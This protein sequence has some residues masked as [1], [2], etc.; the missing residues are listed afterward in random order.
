MA[1]P[2]TWQGQS[3]W[4]AAR[5][6]VFEDPGSSPGATPASPTRPPASETP[7]GALAPTAGSG[8]VRPGAPAAPLPDLEGLESRAVESDDSA[9]PRQASNTV[10]RRSQWDWLDEQGRQ[11]GRRT[12]RRVRRSDLL[13]LLIDAVRASGFSVTDAGDGTPSVLPLRLPEP[14]PRAARAQPHTCT[15]GQRH[16]RPHPTVA[17]PHR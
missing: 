10:L 7:E 15:A 16:A 5:G 4:A 3:P 2:R 17:R 1:K 6:S 9:D 14:A 11:L 12:R 13:R 8:G